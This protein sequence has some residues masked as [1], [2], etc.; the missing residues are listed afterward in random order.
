MDG[1]PRGGMMLQGKL[2]PMDFAA[3]GWLGST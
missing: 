2:G 1:G 3:V